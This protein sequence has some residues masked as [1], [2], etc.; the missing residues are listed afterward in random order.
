[1]IKNK[2]ELN[3]VEIQQLFDFVQTKRV[4][5]KD[6][7]YELVDHLASAIEEKQRVDNSL[8]F[9][10]ALKEVYAGFPV[11]GFN[12]FLTE[13]T[14]AVKNIFYRKFWSSMKDY[15]KSSKI[16]VGIV[17]Y[18]I[19]FQLFST[20]QTY[21]IPAAFIGLFIFFCVGMY[22]S[23]MKIIKANRDDNYLI[24]SIY[25]RFVFFTALFITFIPIQDLFLYIP[26]NLQGSIINFHIYALIFS[27]LHLFIHAF[28]FVF[29]KKLKNEL[30]A[31][32]EHL[33]VAFN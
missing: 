14:T 3:S 23:E 15:F 22:H 17:I 9:D 10:S 6:V 1:M 13:K 8:S 32:Y 12:Q 19:A 31:K 7:Q 20:F 18:F 5:F 21:G 27:I 16:I 4:R 26:N 2:I 24:L 29:P 28:F 33:Q 30:Q 25:A 11:T